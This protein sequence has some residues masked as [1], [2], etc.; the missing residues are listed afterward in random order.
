MKV[1]SLR[2]YQKKVNLTIKVLS[3]NEP[4]EVTSKLDDSKHT[5]TEALVGDDTGTV[6][7]TLWDDDIARVEVGKTYDV[8][9][10]FT[11]LFKNS[12]RLNI[13]RYG[14]LKEG[15]AEITVVNEDNNLSGSVEEKQ[16]PRPD[17][18]TAAAVEEAAEEREGKTET[19][20]E[21][22]AEQAAE[23]EQAETAEEEKEDETTETAEEEKK[24]EAV[25]E[26]EGETEELAAGETTKT[27]EEEKKGESAEE[28]VTEGKEEQASE[29]AAVEEEKQETASEETTEEKKKEE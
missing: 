14:E 3:K 9:N 11:S 8:I 12:L 4:R 24:E 19:A 7:L 22:A 13:G 21:E 1:E 25:V 2:P 23:G 27:I 26:K 17:S 5:V 28:T 20:V 16:E 15:S 6:L 29:E 18:E 10:G